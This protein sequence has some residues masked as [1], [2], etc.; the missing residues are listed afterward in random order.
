MI[1]IADFTESELWIVKSTLHERYGQ[2]IEPALA[3]SELRLDPHSTTLTQCPAL[4]WQADGGVHFVIVKVGDR[5]YRAQF[6]Y[7]GYQQYGTGID[8]FDDLSECIVTL[9]Q[10]QA[11]HELKRA[12]EADREAARAREKAQREELQKI[13]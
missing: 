13:K 9:L 6:F 3:D 12:E 2:E 5:R 10:V 7:R 4:Y 11:D 1:S 8:E